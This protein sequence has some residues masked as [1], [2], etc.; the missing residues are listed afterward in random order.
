MSQN[1][2]E[3]HTRKRSCGDH[4]ARR[5]LPP[6]VARILTVESTFTLAHRTTTSPLVRLSPILFL[7]FASVALGAPVDYA[8][9]VKPLL[10]ERCFACHG[11]LKQNAKLRL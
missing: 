3:C 4:E 1:V 5:T 8:R 10:Q 11:S 6:T 9:E 2:T 7:V